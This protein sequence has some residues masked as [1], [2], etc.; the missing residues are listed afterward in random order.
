MGD[1]HSARRQ[2]RRTLVAVVCVVYPRQA[3]MKA[4]KDLIPWKVT[5]ISLR[6]YDGFWSF[7]PS[8]L[9]DSSSGVW[10]LVLRC[11]DYCM[12]GGTT[13]R[14]S[15]SS[16]GQQTKNAM[17]ILD[18]QSWKPVQIFKMQEKDALPRAATPH[19]GYEDMRLFRTDKGGLQ[20]IAASL[21]LKRGKHSLDGRPQH[22]PPEQV[23]LSFDAEY[24]IVHAQPIRGDGWSSMPQKNWSP[25]TDCVDPRF[26]YS[27]GKGLVFDD[28]GPVHGDAA[29]VIPSARARLVEAPVPDTVEVVEATAPEAA[30]PPLPSPTRPREDPPHDRKVRGVHSGRMKL[31]AGSAS[32]RP[33]SR[34]SARSSTASAL[35]RRPPMARTGDNAVH[36]MGAGRMMT[37]NGLRGGTQLVR[38]AEDTWLGIGHEMRYERGAKYY[39]HTWYVTD[40]RGKMKAASEPCK[41]A[42]EGIE[43]AAGMGIDGDHVVVSFGVDD[44]AAMIGETSLSA[45]MGIL[46]SVA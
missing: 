34:P 3:A 5:D 17:L 33:L 29:R 46:R 44:Y 27:I 4:A 6:P 35:P 8:C 28:H 20:G 39:F 42:V 37:Y 45:V 38:V 2:G 43:F 24:N 12:K 9:F 41:L 36:K 14:G 31:D 32:M 26:I 18:P 30:L 13:I 1:L 7:N 25:Y 40:S 22:Q 23:I 11:A 16:T 15:K 10:M 19:V 21:H